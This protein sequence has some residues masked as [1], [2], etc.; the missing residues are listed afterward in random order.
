MSPRC[1]KKFACTNV[2]IQN[3]QATKKRG[4]Q[5]NCLDIF[6]KWGSFLE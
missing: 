5:K 2:Y 3:P 6:K 4:N 1:R